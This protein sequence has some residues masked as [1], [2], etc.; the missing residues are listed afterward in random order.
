[1]GKA[2]V[3]NA[4]VIGKNPPGNG[5]HSCNASVSHHATNVLLNDFLISG[6]ISRGCSSGDSESE[7]NKLVLLP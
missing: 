6:S 7:A 5:G 2:F 1:M 3:G 4:C